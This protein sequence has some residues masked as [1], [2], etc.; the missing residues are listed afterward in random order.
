[1]G[2]DLERRALMGIATATI[3]SGAVQAAAPALVLAPLHADTGTT[4][5]HL[6]GTIGMFMV[7]VGATQLATLKHPP[8]DRR[9][10][11]W[12]GVQKLGAVAAVAIG[13]RRGVFARRALAVA[14]FDALSGVL[15]F[16]YL[17]HLPR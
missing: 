9:V 11:R 4:P 13:V 15:A 8:Y 6:F 2:S 7:C 1:M 14:G 17:R 12:S 5:R 10:V 3:A 16:H